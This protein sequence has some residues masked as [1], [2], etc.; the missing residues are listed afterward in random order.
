M[1]Q[2]SNLQVEWTAG[3]EC[4]FDQ[5]IDLIRQHLE[6]EVLFLLSGN[7]LVGLLVGP[8]VRLLIFCEL[9]W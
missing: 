9:P 5:G 6:L 4:S 2:G 7:F 8:P 1:T 3:S